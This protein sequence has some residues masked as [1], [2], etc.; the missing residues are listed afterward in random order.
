VGNVQL[1]KSSTATSFDY[2][3]YGTELALCQRYYTTGTVYFEYQPATIGAAAGTANNFP[4]TMRAAATV[5]FGT[6]TN[7]QNAAVGG[8]RA[9][10]ANA[11]FRYCSNSVAAAQT[12][13]YEVFFATAEL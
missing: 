8:T 7:V 3:P 13:A 6:F 11:V 1:E 10:T 2:R 4:V 5:T 12:T 9:S